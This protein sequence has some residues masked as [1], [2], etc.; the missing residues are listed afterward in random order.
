MSTA[1]IFRAARTVFLVFIC[2]GVVQSQQ[3]QY[4]R[5]TPPQH[6]AGVSELGSYTSADLGTVNLSNGALNLKLSLGNVGGRGFWLPLTLNWSSKIWSGRTD[7]E[8]D[9]AGQTKTVAFAESADG[10][11]LMEIFG[12]VGYGWTIGAA[13]TLTVRIVRINQIIS[14]ANIG[15]YTHTVPKLTLM[16]PD[17]SEIEFRDDAY[18]GAPLA[19]DCS[20]YIAASRGTRW[21][22]NDGSGMIFINDANNGV[23]NFNV[24]GVVMSADGMR[25]HFTGSLC[26]SITDRNGNKMTF[27]YGSGVTIT[28]QL[29]RVTRIQQ[30]VADPQNPGVTLAVLV[31][32]PGYNGQN[33]YYKIKSGIMNQHY[34][35]DINPTLPVITGDYDPLSYGYG[36]G[37]ATRLFNHS[38]GLYAQEIDNRD[39]VTELVLPDARSLH[40]NYNQYGEV[41]E[42]QLPTGGKIWYDYA[43]DNTLPAGNSPAWEKSADLHTEVPIDRVLNKRRTFADGTSL[44]CTWDYSYAGTYTQVTATSASGVLL[45]DQRHHFLPAGRYYYYPASSSGALTVLR[46]RSGQRELSG[47]LKLVMQP[48]TS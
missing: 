2:A 29:G 38:Y 45:L 41:A 8:T 14:G 47:G 5:G 9:Q 40:F 24:S 26:D 33:R 19:S 28:D 16:L 22:A 37:S 30:E 42:V 11:Q 1:R 31:T 44:E 10:D 48:E 15:C 7:T 18:D 3:G 25:Y 21:H 43:N 36:W 34:R 23:A 32:L 17:K 35:S 46:I 12:R 20:G 13:P 4:D 27:A 6:V 39:V